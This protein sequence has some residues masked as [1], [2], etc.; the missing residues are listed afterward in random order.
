MD[1]TEPSYLAWAT[2]DPSP[3]RPMRFLCVLPDQTWGSYRR[4]TDIR[5]D[6][7]TPGHLWLYPK[8]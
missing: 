5:E 7:L 3:H 8:I 6:G 2:A 4:L 1:G